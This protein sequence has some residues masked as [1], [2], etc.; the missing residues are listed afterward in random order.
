MPCGE[1]AARQA[2]P[3]D[4]RARRFELAPL[5]Q[6]SAHGEVKLGGG[7]SLLAFSRRS[8]LGLPAEALI[9]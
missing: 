2:E 8:P 4:T 9:L 1:C 7:E 5:K 3:D 6:S